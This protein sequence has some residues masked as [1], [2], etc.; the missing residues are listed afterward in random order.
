MT[1]LNLLHQKIFDLETFSGHIGHGCY[2][3]N[4]IRSVRET[5]FGLK[6]H[7]NYNENV[8]RDFTGRMK[9]VI[10]VKEY[11]YKLNDKWDLILRQGN[12]SDMTEIMMSSNSDCGINDALHSVLRYLYP[13][14]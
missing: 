10:T 11:I 7:I 1:Y 13:T 14:A 4:T 3:K 6:M 2:K 5:K 9:N 12:K 8:P